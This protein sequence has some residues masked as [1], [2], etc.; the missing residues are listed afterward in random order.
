[1]DI[2]RRILIVDAADGRLQQI[3]IDLLSQQISVHYASDIDE[4]LLLAQDVKDKTLAVLFAT[5]LDFERVSKLAILLGLD[6]SAL[7]PAGQRPTEEVVS[8]LAASGVQWH[9]WD[10]PQ[11]ESLRFVMSSILH[12]H[13]PFELRYHLRIPTRL[14]ARVESEGGKFDTSIRDIGLGGACLFGGIVGDEDACGDLFFAVDGEEIQIPIRV[15]WTSGDESPTTN[16]TGVSF[17]DLEPD[18]GAAIDALRS[19]FV[20][21][22][23]VKEAR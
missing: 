12:D 17:V 6:S 23:R 20:E 15:V 14:D 7:I 5:E 4:A 21:R 9:I 2:D 19:A 11:S 3:S 22:Y 13:D 8:A 10:N 18:T 16:V 1:M